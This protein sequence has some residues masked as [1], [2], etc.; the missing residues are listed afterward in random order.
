M[1]TFSRLRLRR[2]LR[3]IQFCSNFKENLMNLRR[4]ITALAV[5]AVFTALAG[6]QTI[7]PVPI[8]CSVTAATTPAIRSEGSTELVGDILITCTGGPAPLTLGNPVDR[9]TITVN[10][11]VPVTSLV[12]KTSGAVAG[13]S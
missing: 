11:G 12:D 4:W 5:L 7:T 9:A 2:E 8:S 10:Y 3:P 6:A 1:V 13:A